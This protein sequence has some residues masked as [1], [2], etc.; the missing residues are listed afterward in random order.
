MNLAIDDNISDRL[1]LTKKSF[2][3][4]C[5]TTSEKLEIILEMFKI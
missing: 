5:I 2:E 3:I 1:E 4:I